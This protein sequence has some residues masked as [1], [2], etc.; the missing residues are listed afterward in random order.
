MNF[1]SFFNMLFSFFEAQR[2]AFISPESFRNLLF[3]GLPIVLLAHR[4]EHP[5]SSLPYFVRFPM[6]NIKYKL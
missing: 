4:L 1:L 6:P 3:A 5:S 2:G